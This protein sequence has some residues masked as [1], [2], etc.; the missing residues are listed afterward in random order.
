MID[1]IATAIYITGM[2]VTAIIL[3]STEVDDMEPGDSFPI[4]VMLL[5]VL[6]WPLFLMGLAYDSFRL[7]RAKNKDHDPDK[8]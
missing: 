5:F 3:I 2:A 1:S 4:L 6:C 8:Y 7:W